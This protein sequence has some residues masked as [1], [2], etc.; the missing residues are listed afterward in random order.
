MLARIVRNLQR[1]KSLPPSTQLRKIY[2]QSTWH[3]KPLI[4]NSYIDEE[5]AMENKIRFTAV[6]REDFE[7]AKIE[8][9]SVSNKKLFKRINSE[10]DRVT[11][12]H[13]LRLRHNE[14]LGGI[15]YAHTQPFL[16][17]SAENREIR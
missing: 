1:I 7:K 13:R 11:R 16:D 4:F 9:L 2:D 8:P 12:A 6:H 15:S 10:T 17:R 3:A 5:R 14:L